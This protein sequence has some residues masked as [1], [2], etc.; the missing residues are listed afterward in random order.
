ME[1]RW[2]ILRNLVS[3]DGLIKNYL[4]SSSFTAN[5]DNSTNQLDNL[6]IDQHN[7]ESQ[8]DETLSNKKSSNELSIYYHNSTIEI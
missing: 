8:F 7:N 3:K 2:S 6:S 5:K 1:K 4:S